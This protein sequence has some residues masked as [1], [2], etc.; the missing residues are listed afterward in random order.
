MLFR[1]LLILEA[2]I[3]QSAG[4]SERSQ[5]DP[6]RD[7]SRQT[8]TLYKLRLKSFFVCRMAVGLAGPQSEE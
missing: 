4:P 3:S 6:E 1:K 7:D 5:K 8:A 2:T